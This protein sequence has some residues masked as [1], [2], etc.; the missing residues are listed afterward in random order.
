MSVSLKPTT[1]KAKSSTTPSNH[2]AVQWC[3]LPTSHILQ[4]IDCLLLPLRSLH[5]PQ[6]VYAADSTQSRHNIQHALQQ[7]SP[8]T[9]PRQ[10]RNTATLKQLFNCTSICCFATTHLSTVPGSS[11]PATCA[12]PAQRRIK[13]HVATRTMQCNMSVHTP[14]PP[15]SLHP[16]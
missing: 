9:L 4:L 14:S 13:Q 16:P 10:S 8:A 1:Q 12:V 11:K 3:K 15:F 2:I 7:L 6:Q 5:C